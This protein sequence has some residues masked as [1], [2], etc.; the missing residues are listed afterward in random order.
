MLLQASL[1]ALKKK[2]KVKEYRH[3]PDEMYLTYYQRADL[4][5]TALEFSL[6]LPLTSP[7][8]IF[9]FPTV[10]CVQVDFPCFKVL[11][12]KCLTFNR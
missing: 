1:A 11:T 8:F 7:V 3:L 12:I 5:V 10:E 4:P 2:K 6:C 9:I